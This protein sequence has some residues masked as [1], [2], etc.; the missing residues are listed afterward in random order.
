MSRLGNWNIVSFLKFFEGRVPH[1]LNLVQASPD[2][3]LS[4]FNMVNH[5]IKNGKILYP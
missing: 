3:S 2:L 5:K 1:W 4:I